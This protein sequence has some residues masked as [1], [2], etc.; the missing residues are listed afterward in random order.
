MGNDFAY[1]LERVARHHGFM[2]KTV[3]DAI[4]ATFHD[5]VDV[6]TRC[7]RCKTR[8]QASIA[9]QCPGDEVEIDRLRR[10]LAAAALM[11][12]RHAVFTAEPK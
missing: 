1:L 10:W 6:V 12:Q 8:G 7:Y 4:T 2:V 3:G 5:P 9:A 11:F